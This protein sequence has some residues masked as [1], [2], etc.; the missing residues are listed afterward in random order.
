V[1]YKQFPVIEWDSPEHNINNKNVT[2][3]LVLSIKITSIKK[4]QQSGRV[5][6]QSGI[7]G[8]VTGNFKSQ[9]KSGNSK[10]F[11]K[12]SC[13]F[14]SLYI[15]LNLFQRLFFYVKKFLARYAHNNCPD[16]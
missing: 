2:S 8:N 3:H 14:H 9:G 15:F 4:S 13:N 1:S 11:C 12:W 10:E 7:P 5:Y 6:N 16:K